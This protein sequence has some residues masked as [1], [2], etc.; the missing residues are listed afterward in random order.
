MNFVTKKQTNL[1][2]ETIPLKNNIK[3]KPR[4]FELPQNDR[5]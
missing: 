3:H 5:P 4:V 1:K 2:H